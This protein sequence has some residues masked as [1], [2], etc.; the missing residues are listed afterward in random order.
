MRRNGAT[1][2]RNNMNNT[3]GSETRARRFSADAIVPGAAAEAYR[4]LTNGADFDAVSAEINAGGAVYGIA[5]KDVAVI[6]YHADAVLGFLNDHG[7]G[8]L[9]DLVAGIKA[10]RSGNDSFDAAARICGAYGIP[11]GAAWMVA[12]YAF[13]LAYGPSNFYAERDTVIKHFHTGD[14]VGA[15]QYALGI[16]KFSGRVRRCLDLIRLGT[17]ASILAVELKNLAEAAIMALH[18]DRLVRPLPCFEELYG[19]KPDGSRGTVPCRYGDMELYPGDEDDE[20]DGC[21]DENDGCEED[22][23][24]GARFEPVY[25]PNFLMFDG[26]DTAIWD[27]LK[28][29]YVRC[30]DGTI[31]LHDGE[32]ADRLRDLNSGADGTDA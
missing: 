15:L 9:D 32:P 13:E 27:N 1:E 3:V 7:C 20:E 17:P 2:E 8:V 19:V 16:C 12:S 6:L 4:A 22:A 25:V 23:G 18:N 30:P 10:G 11:D 28:D 5:P 26:R 24:S 14:Y 29:G 21:T 31:E